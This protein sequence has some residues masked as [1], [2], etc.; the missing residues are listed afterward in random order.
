VT[1]PATLVR[2]FYDDLWNAW[3]DTAVPEVLHPGLRFRGSLGQVTSGLDEWRSYRDGVRRSAP[4]FHNEVVD[5][6]VTGDRAAARL[7]WSGTHAGALLGIAPTGRRFRYQGAAFFTVTAGLI[8]E[9]WVV[10]DLGPLRAQL[11]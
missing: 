4:D 9:V 5:L 6:V 10:G 3:D 1:D 2:R 7:E 8:S 11:T